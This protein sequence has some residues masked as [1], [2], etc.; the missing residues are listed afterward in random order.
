MGCSICSGLL[1]VMI[2]RVHFGP[3]RFSGL[4]IVSQAA[5]GK[6]ISQAMIHVLLLKAET[7][8]MPDLSYMIR[9]VFSDSLRTVLYEMRLRRQ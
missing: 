3:E 6:C 5:A 9:G 1:T 8:K 4:E 7:L 2:Y